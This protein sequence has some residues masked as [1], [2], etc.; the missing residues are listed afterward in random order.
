MEHDKKS[1]VLAEKETDHTFTK[2]L[3]PETKTIQIAAIGDLLIHDRV[4]NTAKTEAGYNFLPMFENVQKYLKE[5]AITIANQETI[6]GGTDIGL[7]SYPRFNSPFELAANLQEIGV[8]LVTMANNHTLD[9]GEIAINNSI[10]YY[11][12]IGMEYTGSFKNKNDQ[13][14]IRVI[15]TEEQISVAFLSYTYGTNGIAVPE[16]K[17]YLVNLIDRNQIKKDIEIAQK[18]ADVTVVSYHFGEE[19]ERYPNQ[20]QK[21]LAQFAADL[22]VDVVIGHHPHVLQPMEWV[23]GENGDRTLVAYSLGNFLSGQDKLYRRIGGIFQF[24]V[25]K[26]IHQGKET[27][28]VH[29]PSFLPTFVDYDLEDGRMTNFSIM[30]LSEVTDKQLPDSDEHFIEIDNH[31]KQW[32][33]ELEII[34]K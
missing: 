20:T 12:K 30:P 17:D 6:T 13:E 34:K 1:F 16:G 2:S 11:E 14:R 7:S 21:Q 18:K 31:M 5:P 27:I 23:E 25:E 9:R 3:R 19:Y 33:P 29:S 24:A 8:D 28:Q 4:Y 32:L 22:G 26:E 15:E 10:Q